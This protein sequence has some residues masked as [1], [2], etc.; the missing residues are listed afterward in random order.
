MSGVATPGGEGASR[1]TLTG[2]F[3]W[4]IA[5]FFFLY[6]FFLRTFLGSLEPQI[7]K[8]L[9]LNATTFSII[10]SCYYL[11]YGLMQIPV[12]M[13]V[14]RFGVKA[15]M[16]LASIVCGISALLFGAAQGFGMALAARMIM[17]FGSSF[18]FI[19]L[20]VIAREWFPRKNFGLFAGIS[21]LI[22]T[23]GP[24]LA[25]GP[26]IIFLKN[27]GL[28]WRELVSSLGGVGFGIAVMSF[29][30]VRLPKAGRAGHFR[31]LQAP[32]SLKEQ[33]R[34][35]L[36]NGQAWLVATY[37]A[38]I[39]TAIATLGAI[40]GTRV[41][42][43]KGL[44]QEHAGDAVSILWV[45]YA[46]GCPIAGFISDQIKRRQAVMVALGLLATLATAALWL[47]GD[48]SFAFF[49]M[50]FFVI[51][52]SGGAQN[53]GFA[54]I[55]EKVNE[56]LSA[57]SMGLNNG[58]MLLFD[59]VNPI[60]FGLLVTL[61]LQDKNSDDFTSKNFDWALAYLPALCLIATAISFFLIRET[62]CKP[63]KGVTLVGQT[64]GPGP[65]AGA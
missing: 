34:L 45:G 14:D 55:V 20:L 1:I 7:M 28:D 49:A 60:I 39:Y 35:L 44:D 59:T 15:T 40:W 63:Q 24:I 2:V 25:G 50:L 27:E 10:G 33:I 43:A 23:I 52:L 47:S 5:A 26:L 6:E 3:I 38:L 9:Q 53:V 31:V 12:G 54:T 46:L 57:T 4:A 42:I 11:T 16:V 41:L 56:R 13:V 58:L 19:A 29:L 37:S 62:Y 21:Q 22:G 61:T 17:G 18:A 32:F 48:D 30:F 51:G 65:D 36:T 64:P 8:S